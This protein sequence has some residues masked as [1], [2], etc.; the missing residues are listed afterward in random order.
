MK[1]KINVT[2][3]VK[4]IIPYLSFIDCMAEVFASDFLT[5]PYMVGHHAY[6][7]SFSLNSNTDISTGGA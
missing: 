5:F 4:L 6:M 2:R 3:V 1:N 7:G